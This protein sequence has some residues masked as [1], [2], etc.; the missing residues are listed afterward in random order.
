MPVRTSGRKTASS[1][2]GNMVFG[3]SHPNLP[4]PVC[5]A[6]GCTAPPKL[7]LRLRSPASHISDWTTPYVSQACVNQENGRA[8]TA[9]G[10]PAETCI[11]ELQ[12][13]K[14]TTTLSH[15]TRPSATRIFLIGVAQL[16]NDNLQ[17]LQTWNTEVAKQTL[18]ERNNV[19]E[20]VARL[21]DSLDVSIGSARRELRSRLLYRRRYLI[22]FLPGKRHTSEE[23]VTRA[24]KVVHATIE[25]LQA[26]NKIHLGTSAKQPHLQ[27]KKRLLLE[28]RT[29]SSNAFSELFN[30][31]QAI[32][33]QDVRSYALNMLWT[34]FP[35]PRVPDRVVGN[36]EDPGDGYLYDEKEVDR[37]KAILQHLHQAWYSIEDSSLYPAPPEL[38]NIAKICLVLRGIQRRNFLKDFLDKKV[39]D[40]HLPMERHKIKEVLTEENK[41]YT[42]IFSTEQYRA[43]TRTWDKGHHLEIEEEEPL[44]LEFVMEYNKGSYGKVVMVKDSLTGA[45]YARK[46]QRTSAEAQENAAYRKH[47]KEETER[48]RNLRHNHVVQLVKTYQRGRVYAMILKPAATTDLERLIQRY[49]GN[50]YDA[51]MYSKTREWSGPILLY[52]FGCLSRGLEYIHSLNI[53]HKD[54]K[55]ANILYAKAFDDHGPRLLWADFGLAYDFSATGNSKTRTTR[56]YSQRYAA[57]EIVASRT[58]L[59]P[60]RTFNVQ[61]DL[62]RI[63]KG[64][65]ETAVDAEI[66]SEFRES[67]EN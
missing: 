23:S 7:R 57:P 36:A 50:K 4:V 66:E 35:E 5:Y 59:I 11:T 39:L 56:V 53:R 2:P 44:P 6:L 12:A 52:A 21:F 65:E 19:V 17:S 32:E 37:V 45:F 63:V 16:V 30:N 67:E 55:P 15:S 14:H 49:Y 27:S 62:D 61:P 24:L 60:E 51:T 28:G 9:L 40:N 3:L 64:A 34:F 48:L 29:Q 42:A 38:P 46:Q 43:V 10:H 31:L 8:T 25:Q 20:G 1:K 54:I 33:P 47:L 41:E 13:L 58:R 18:T 26:Q 22:G